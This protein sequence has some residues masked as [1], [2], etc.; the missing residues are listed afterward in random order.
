MIQYKE[1]SELLQD[2][3]DRKISGITAA[4]KTDARLEYLDFTVPY[5]YNP[6]V[7]VTRKNFSEKL[8]FEKLSNSSMKTLVM[9][10]YSV[11]DHIKTNYPMLQYSTINSV[12]EG[13]RMVAFG[14]ADVMIIELIS[15]T[16]AIDEDNI[17]NLMINTETLYNSN[18]SIATRNDWPILN[19][20]FNKGLAQISEAEKNEIKTKWIPFYRKKIYENTFFWI[21]LGSTF[22]TL[23]LILATIFFWNITLKKLVKEKTAELEKSKELLIY[24]SYHDDLTKLYNRAFYNETLELFVS[25]PPIPLSIIMADLNCL[26]ITNDTLGHEDGDK[27]IKLVADILK[28]TCRNSDIIARIGG[29]EFVVLMPKTTYENAKEIVEKIKM[30][31][32]KAP[33]NPIEISLAMGYATQI[34]SRENIKTIFKKAEDLMYENKIHESPKTYKNIIDT[35]KDRLEKNTFETHEHCLR[36]KEMSLKIG[37]KL[38]FSKE[39]LNVLEKVADLH[40]IGLV[41]IPYE[42]LNKSEGLTSFEKNKIERHPDFGFR[43]ASS[44]KMLEVAEGILAHHEHWDG[45]GYPNRLKGESIPIMSRIISVVDA[46]DVMT[47]GR[48]YKKA[49]SKLEAI[50]ELKRCAGAQFDPKIVD[51]FINYII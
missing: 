30:A 5:I 40:D 13:L 9:E 38:N 15:A 19:D 23:A 21:V 7:I 39:E 44:A 29:D 24:K 22:I 36:L 51:L 25:N 48:P 6:D 1:W 35:L 37:E 17:T 12:K 18:L 26:K 3:K 10:D 33:K 8:A 31:C 11:V 27:L 32:E 42:I 16:V 43:I 45:T 47:N 46:Y 34:D 41:T 28:Q 14:E 49:V 20:I 50:E 2:A 4:T